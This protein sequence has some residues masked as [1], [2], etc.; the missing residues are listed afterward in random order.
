MINVVPFTDESLKEFILSIID[1]RIEVFAEYPFLYEGDRKFEEKYLQKFNTMKDSIIA[2]AFDGDKIIGAGTGHPFTYE[3]EN[4]KELF[5]KHDR[6]PKDYY[7]IGEVLLQKPYRAQGLGKQIYAQIE[8]YVRKLG[9]YPHISLFT[10]LRPDNHP[11]KP[12]NYFSLISYW[13]KLGFTKHPE[14]IETATYQE[15]GEK[16]KSPK[17]MIFMIKSL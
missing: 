6:D 4:F 13:E 10:I 11:K 17:E 1:L 7:F 2:I 16:E 8:A 3:R 15:V 5:K 12:E 14:L 9:C